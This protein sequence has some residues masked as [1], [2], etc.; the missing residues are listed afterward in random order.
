MPPGLSAALPEGT[1]NGAVSKT[2]VSSVDLFPTLLALAALEAPQQE[3]AGRSLVAALE[4]PEEPLWG[5]GERAVLLTGDCELTQRGLVSYGVRTDRF[6]YI[7]YSWTATWDGKSSRVPWTR[8]Q[9]FTETR[10]FRQ[11]KILDGVPGELYDLDS[12]RLEHDNLLKSH[13]EKRT[14]KDV[15]KVFLHMEQH[16]QQLTNRTYACPNNGDKKGCARLETRKGWALPDWTN[17]CG[18]SQKWA[19]R[20]PCRCAAQ[21]AYHD[22]PWVAWEK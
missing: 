6:R 13:R 1:T 15:F 14:T 7:S 9:G 8:G 18:L 16:L 5:D 17:R 19:K 11:A 21:K 2:L 12:D 20:C 3:L 22:L 10:K 4:T